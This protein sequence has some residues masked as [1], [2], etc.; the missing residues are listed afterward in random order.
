Y[1]GRSCHVEQSETCRPNRQEIR[2]TATAL[3]AKGS[4]D[5]KRRG[6]SMLDYP[7]LPPRL[8]RVFTINPLYFV[9]FCTY[10]RKKLLA[11]NAVMMPSWSSQSER[12]RNVLSPPVATSSCRIICIFLS[13]GRT[14]SGWAAG[15]EC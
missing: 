5:I 6:N 9:T 4:S 14:T 15:L 11:R 13:V 3:L 8:A 12:T 2:S 10:R 1:D 7:R